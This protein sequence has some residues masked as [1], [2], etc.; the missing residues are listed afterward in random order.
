MVGLEGRADDGQEHE[1][2]GQGNSMTRVPDW[3]GVD[4]DVARSAGGVMALASPWENVVRTGIHPWP[5]P[6]LLQKVYQSRQLRAFVG[7][8]NAV[9][10]SVLGFYSD[11]QSIHSEDAITWSVF[12]PIAYASREVRNPFIRDLLTLIGVPC[13]PFEAATVWLWRRL[14]HPDTL[15]PGGPE[16]DFGIQ[17]DT[18]FLLGEAKWLSPVS[19]N[20]GV[21]GDT[22]QLTLR[23][24][25]CDKYGRRLLPTCRRFVVLG[26]SPEGGMVPHGDTTADGVTLHG[27]DTTWEA[28]IGL[29]SHPLR[30]ELGAYLDW[31]RRNSRRPDDS[32]V[33]PR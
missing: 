1:V 16:I 24:E 29:D 28:V 21:L 7:A 22:D 9:A 27:R 30:Q 5:P 25:F 26:V 12:G 3:R 17:T 11:L 2:G 14:P 32:S 33:T 13:D 20:Q 4:V 10:T 31:K 18:L 19:A 23:R 6:E 15:V 8:D